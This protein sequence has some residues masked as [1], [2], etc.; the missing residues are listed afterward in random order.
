ME[1]SLQDERKIRA[2]VKLFVG[3]QTTVKGRGKEVNRSVA[4]A[5][6]PAQILHGIAG[7]RVQHR[8]AESQMSGRYGICDTLSVLVC[9]IDVTAFDRGPDRL[10][11]SLISRGF[12]HNSQPEGEWQPSDTHI[13][14]TAHEK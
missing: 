3:L 7:R 14:I 5:V 6:L 8:Q 4:H 11:T 1:E 2:R 9:S 13:G 12:L 10:S